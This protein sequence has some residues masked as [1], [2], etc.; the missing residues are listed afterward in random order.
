[1]PSVRGLGR[2]GADVLQHRFARLASS[3]DRRS[4]HARTNHGPP[5]RTRRRR[6]SRPLSDHEQREIGHL[7]DLD[8][9]WFDSYLLERAALER[10]L[11]STRL[12]PHLFIAGPAPERISELGFLDT[13][14]TTTSKVA[15]DLVAD[16]HFRRATLQEAGIRTGKTR[17]TQ[18]YRAI[19]TRTQLASLLL[20]SDDGAHNVAAEAHTDLTERLAEVLAAFP[21][22]AHAE[23]EFGLDDHTQSPAQQRFSITGMSVRPRLWP[24]EYCHAAEPG[25]VARRILDAVRPAHAG[26]ADVLTAEVFLTTRSGAGPDQRHCV[27]QTVADLSLDLVEPVTAGDDGLAAVVSGAPCCLAAFA[28]L[29]M[30]GRRSCESVNTRP[31]SAPSEPAEPGDG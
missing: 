28:A 16:R 19:A 10:G 30:S 17:A 2:A 9:R 11:C 29:T 31:V 4:R 26:H 6:V 15:R 27:E 25:D 14:A 20:E 5:E 12:L 18:R 3:A 1:M 13:A 21:G 22:L 7:D 24:H 8:D 23:I